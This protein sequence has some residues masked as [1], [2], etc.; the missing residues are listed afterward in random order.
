MKTEYTKWEPDVPLADHTDQIK[1]RGIRGMWHTLEKKEWFPGGPTLW[2]LEE[3]DEGDNWPLTI[4]DDHGNLVL[5][6]CYNGWDDLDECIEDF[7]FV[8]DKVFRRVGS[9][10]DV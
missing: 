10:L 2:L 9:H 8:G 7:V 3:D 4:V 1:V 5:E 6:N